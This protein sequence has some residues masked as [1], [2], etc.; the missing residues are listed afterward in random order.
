MSKVTTKEIF[1]N[2]IED[3][4]SKIATGVNVFADIQAVSNASTN[5]G[6]TG[7]NKWHLSGVIKAKGFESTRFATFKQIQAAGGQVRKGEKSFPVFFWGTMFTFRGDITVS[8]NSLDDAIEKAKKKNPAIWHGD[9]L[10]RIMF[11]KHFSAFNLDQ[12]DGAEFTQEE[13][14][15]LEDPVE[16]L[17]TS[18]GTKISCGSVPMYD[19]ELDTIFKSEDSEDEELVVRAL[20]DS[21]GHKDRLNREFEY[22]EE[23][24]VG[25]IGTSFLSTSIGHTS[26]LEYSEELANHW[27]D[28]LNENP[29]FLY[30][31]SSQAQKAC[32]YLFDKVKAVKVEKL[33]SA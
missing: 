3:F 33:A 9:F 20:I 18:C 29:M 24:L 15:V 30:K 7:F 14:E 1:N 25:I 4:K 28:I 31:A 5:R 8:A 19:S 10:K 21:T 13:V 26:E 23:E 6:Y 12:Q 22:A 32:D 17:L 2:I 16:Q 27:L 11:I